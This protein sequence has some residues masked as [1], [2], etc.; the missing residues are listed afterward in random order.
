V[1]LHQGNF[2]GSSVKGPKNSHV[3]EKISS[4]NQ[5][6]VETGEKPRKNQVGKIRYVGEVESPEISYSSPKSFRRYEKTKLCHK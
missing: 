6:S 4:G 3:F 5:L 1:A 2:L